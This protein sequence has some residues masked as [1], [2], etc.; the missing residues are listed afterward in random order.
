MPPVGVEI[1]F[2]DG[3]AFVSTTPPEDTTTQGAQVDVVK[4]TIKYNQ[5][6]DIKTLAQVTG[7]SK[8]RLWNILTKH[9]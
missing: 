4:N 8:D 9:K 6:I 7:L 1:S 5:E 3:C 2:L